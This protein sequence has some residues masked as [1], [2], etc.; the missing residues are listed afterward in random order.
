MEIIQQ[1][2]EREFDIEIITTAPSVS[3]KVHLTSGEV[4][5]VDAY[6]GGYNL[7]IA[8]CTAYAAANGLY[9]EK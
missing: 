2:I 5:D 6:T 3:Y 4:I 1:R 8:F 7:Q 9:S